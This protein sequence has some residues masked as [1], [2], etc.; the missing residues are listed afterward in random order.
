MNNKEQIKHY[1]PFEGFYNSIYDSIIDSI[2]EDEI[3]EGYLTEDEAYMLNYKPIFEAMSEHI[4]DVI[5][6]EFCFDFDLS[7]ELFIYDGLSS[8]KFYNYST[9]KILSVY[10][11]NI[12]EL[13]NTFLKKPDFV[14]YVN[15]ASKSRSGFASFYEGIDEV[16]SNDEV[17]ME[18]LF[19]W[20]VLHY[21][22]DEIINLTT[23]NIHEVIYENLTLNI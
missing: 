1:I 13:K 19:Q 9:D 14:E 10:T 8:P 17:F 15:E 22:R 4:F 5:I 6:E 16:C 18:Y 7:T 23:D 21:N 11:G 3:N 2:I 12:E 20:Y